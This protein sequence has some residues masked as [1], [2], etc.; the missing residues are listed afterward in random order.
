MK[1]FIPLALGH[2]DFW[3]VLGLSLEDF[4]F[5]CLF[6]LNRAL[7]FLREKKRTLHVLEC[8]KEVPYVLVTTALVGGCGQKRAKSK[9]VRATQVAHT[10]K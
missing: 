2:G 4:V 9:P 10:E 3:I 6:F 5:F 8:T 7:L 1:A